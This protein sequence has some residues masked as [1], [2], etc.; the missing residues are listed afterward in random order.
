MTRLRIRSSVRR[1][2]RW[3][4]AQLALRTGKAHPLFSGPSRLQQQF[5]A[6]GG[7]YAIFNAC[8]SRLYGKKG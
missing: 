2:R 7:A 3:I 6:L 4:S 8:D 1:R 5:F